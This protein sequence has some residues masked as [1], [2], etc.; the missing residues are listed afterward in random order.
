MHKLAFWITF[1]MW[2]TFLSLDKG[3]RWEALLLPQ[4]DVRDFVDSPWNTSLSLRSGWVWDGGKV[5][6]AAGGEGEGTLNGNIK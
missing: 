2:D 3:V 5:D 6:R 1:P 4:G